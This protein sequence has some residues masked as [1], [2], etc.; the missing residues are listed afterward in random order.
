MVGQIIKNIFQ[1]IDDSNYECQGQ[2]CS[3]LRKKKDP[4]T[5]SSNT[6]SN[7]NP[8]NNLNTAKTQSQINKE[9]ANIKSKHLITKFKFDPKC[10]NK[11]NIAL[12]QNKTLCTCSPIEEYYRNEGCLYINYSGRILLIDC[13]KD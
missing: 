1:K 7:E 3:S 10:K 13:M 2:L 6:K 11:K 5:I 8:N 4:N 12:L 9:N